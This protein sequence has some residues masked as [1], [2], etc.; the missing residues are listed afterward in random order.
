M[1]YKII[2]GVGFFNSF[3]FLGRRNDFQAIVKDMIHDQ[4]EYFGAAILEEGAYQHG[5]DYISKL[6][7]INELQQ[8]EQLVNELLLK[9]NDNQFANSLT[10]KLSNEWSLRLKVIIF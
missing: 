2:F 6:H 7:A 4:V 1:V 5:Y 9:P 8:V 3:R 10:T